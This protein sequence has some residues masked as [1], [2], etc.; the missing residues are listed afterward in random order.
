M[1]DGYGH[2]L[3]Q[4]WSLLTNDLTEPYCADTLENRMR[5]PMDVLA[6]VGKRVR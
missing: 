2:L 3:D 1:T 4:F 6:L 5:F